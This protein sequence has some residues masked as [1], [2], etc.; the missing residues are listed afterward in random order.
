MNV[1]TT[2]TGLRALLLRYEAQL[3]EMEK[4]AR[5]CCKD[6]APDSQTVALESEQFEAFWETEFNDLPYTPY[7]GVAKVMCLKTWRERN[8]AKV[9]LNGKSSA[10]QEMLLLL[11]EEMC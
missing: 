9:F 4:D 8:G 2:I 10:Y 5:R 3:R 11:K 1:P 7:V 6:Y